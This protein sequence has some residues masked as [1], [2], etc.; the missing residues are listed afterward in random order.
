MAGGTAPTIFVGVP[1][2]HGWDLIDETM[3]SIRDQEFK[4]FRVLISVDGCDERSAVVCAKYTEDPRFELVVQK[5]RLGW[6]GNL[7]W[8]MR[9]STCAFFCYWQQDDICATSYL[10]VLYEYATQH[11]EAACVY[12]DVQWFGSCID[13]D[14]LPSVTGPALKRVLELLDSGNTAPFRG[15]VRRSAL[16]Y[17]G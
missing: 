15:L 11:P 9:Q 6:S 3:R 7:N 14:E 16:V 10:R 5:E 1:V 13:R 12:T 8:L 2:Y 4:D 17:C